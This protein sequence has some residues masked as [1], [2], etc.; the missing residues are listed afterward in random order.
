MIVAIYLPI[1]FA[2]AQSFPVTSSFDD[3]N[4]GWVIFDDGNPAAW[5]STGGFPG[6]YARLVD[7]GPAPTSLLAPIEYTGDW[8]SLDGVGMISY[9]HLVGIQSVI[10]E[11]FNHQITLMGPHGQAVWEGPMPSPP[12]AGW[13]SYYAV[14]YESDW[15]VKSGTWTGLL[16]DVQSLIIRY[17]LYANKSSI[18]IEGIDNVFVGIRIIG[19]VNCDNAVNLLDVAPFI[20]LMTSGTFDIKG[21]VNQDG[22]VDLLDVGPFVELLTN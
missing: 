15:S 21:D 11:T 12:N 3:G 17:E 7:A 19:D 13:A 2:S 16:S 6:G 20:D 5:L 14:I 18:D 1:E 22:A 4:E 8:S 9:D 10:V